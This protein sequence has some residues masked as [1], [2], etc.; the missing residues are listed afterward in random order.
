MS[1]KKKAVP[2]KRGR[3]TTYNDKTARA[4]CDRIAD[5]ESLRAICKDPGF[6]PARTF[7]QWVWDDREGIY[8]HYAKAR[9]MQAWKMF[10]EM[11]DIADD[12]SNDYIKDEDGNP[13]TAVN[14][15]HLRRCELKLATRKWHL[16]HVLPK[17]FGNKQGVNPVNN[18]VIVTTDSP[19]K[20]VNATE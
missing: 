7:T 11:I 1:G 9:Q 19:A 2:K 17:T 12:D 8:A 14:H 4:I 15:A 20:V 10:D 13:T 16:S 3:P 18:Q 6:P 5:G